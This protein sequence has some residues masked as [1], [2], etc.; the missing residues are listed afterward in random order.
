MSLDVLDA[1]VVR[2]MEKQSLTVI[3]SEIEN[4][5]S[6]GCS[7]TESKV[8]TLDKHFN[9]KGFVLKS[10]LIGYKIG[11]TVYALSDDEGN[12]YFVVTM[13]CAATYQIGLVAAHLTQEGFRGLLA[14]VKVVDK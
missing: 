12:R 8:Y 10:S 14:I 11:D 7:L 4:A 5:Q 6:F 2:I 13:T 9:S 1:L 3:V